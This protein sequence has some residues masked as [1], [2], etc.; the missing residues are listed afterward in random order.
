METL[1]MLITKEEIKAMSAKERAELLSI[2]WDVIEDDPYVD[3][4]AEESE[5]ELRLIQESLEEY[6]RDPSKVKTWDEA[7]SELL[8][9]KDN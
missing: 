9:R 4:L 3:D 6:K 1:I 7:Y 8:R 5:E 2:L